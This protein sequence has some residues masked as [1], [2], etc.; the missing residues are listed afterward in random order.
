MHNVA[1]DL[2]GVRVSKETADVDYSKDRC[3][4]ESYAY[5]N[6][7]RVRCVYTNTHTHRHTRTQA[8]RHTG[9]QAH[10]HTGT[11]AHRHTGTQAHRHTHTPT[12]THTHNTHT[13]HTHTHKQTHTFHNQ[14]IPNS[15]IPHIMI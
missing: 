4:R 3:T 11:Q 2:A 10:R 9:T 5:V 7:H 12:Q 13:T 15:K 1:L 14:T 8:H 6:F